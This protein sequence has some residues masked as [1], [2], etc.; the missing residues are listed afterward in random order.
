LP[1]RAAIISAVSPNCV[2]GALGSAPAF[3]SLSSIAALPFIAASCSG[4]TPSRLAADTFAPARI[5]VSAMSTSSSRTAQCNAVVPSTC[6][7]LTLAFCRSRART[8]AASRFIAASATSL[9]AAQALA[10]ASSTITPHPSVRRID[11]VSLP[12][13]PREAGQ[14]TLR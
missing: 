10:E 9:P 6:G 14:K 13:P 3:I 5:S 2:S 1:V 4:R 8:R 11:I 7:V 12:Q